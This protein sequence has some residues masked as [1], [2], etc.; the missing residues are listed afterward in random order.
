[1]VSSLQGAGTAALVPTHRRPVW[2]AAHAANALEAFARGGVPTGGRKGARVSLCL[3][4]DTS[5]DDG[6]RDASAGAQ[7]WHRPALEARHPA[8]LHVC[9]VIPLSGQAAGTRHPQ[10][11]PVLPAARAVTVGSG[12][13][14]DH[15]CPILS[16]RV[17]TGTGVFT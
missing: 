8:A 4:A 10:G 11:A 12:A 6:H 16:V 7:H 2:C 15:W 14:K 5:L 1:M 17:C 3:G 13:H 9:T